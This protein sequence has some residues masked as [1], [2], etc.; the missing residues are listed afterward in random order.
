MSDHGEMLGD[1][2]LILKGGHFYDGLARVPL[3][4][5]W[6][7]HIQENVVSD[8]LIELVDIATTLL[9][10][11]GLEVPYYMQGKSLLPI[12]LGEADLHHHKDSVYCEYYYSLLGKI[13]LISYD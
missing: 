1:H 12:L 4:M 2:G 9:E 3:I 10:L 11:A 5:S 8:A 13:D 6:P 7:G